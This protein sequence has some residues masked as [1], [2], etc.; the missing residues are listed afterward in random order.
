M[1]KLFELL[2]E[3]LPSS[4]L[5][6]QTPWRN[7]EDQIPYLQLAALFAIFVYVVE[8]VL[9]SRQLR[10][11]KDPKA[12]NPVPDRIPEEKFVKSLSYG[13]DKLSFG[14]IST[15]FKLFEGLVLLFVGW[16][17]YAW[18]LA[19]LSCKK[20]G[21]VSST[22][23]G[24]LYIE[25]MT[26]A[27]FVFILSV[28]STIIDMPFS[29][30]STFVIEERHGFNKQTLFLFFKDAALQLVLTLVIG[31][32]VISGIIVLVRNGG[33]Y[34]Y[35]FI[36][37]FLFVFQLVMMTIYPEWI[38]P[39]FNE[40]KPLD[41]KKHGDLKKQIEGLASKVE[42]PLTKLFVV[43]GSKRSN[44]SNAYFY[45]FFKNKRIVLFDTLLT[46]VTTP[47][48]LAILGH[49]IGH[50]ALWHTIQGFVIA[51]VYS[52]ALFATFHF[53]QSNAAL[54]ASFG[55]SFGDDTSKFPVFI[56]LV[57]FTSTYWTPVD[58]TLK[59]F[60][61]INSR[62]NEFA[63]DAYGKKLG[64][65]KELASGLLKL[66]IENLGNMVPDPW[67]S[68]YHFSHPPLVERL[69]PLEKGE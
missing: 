4:P 11:F 53:I 28:Q 17:P 19:S 45:G 49:E 41:E 67:Y 29:L 51:Q 24:D 9:D 52:F 20:V 1:S 63:A 15:T 26:T 54:F 13:G 48:L 47:E 38:A 68:V 43:D 34:Y 59:F 8:R 25:C 60:L 42:F 62:N 27:V 30:Y 69:A 33:Q 32:P 58:H 50:W 14:M 23:S 36:W 44:H 65:A 10:R 40:F 66:Q 37:A 5:Y 12:K 64:Y 16:L 7:K 57:L 2:R 3:H 22:T 56:S 18:D 39:L 55:F 6:K 21:L 35:V 61:N 31:T 46:Q